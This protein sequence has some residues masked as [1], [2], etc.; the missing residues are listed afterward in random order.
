MKTLLLALCIFQLF[1]TEIKA[2]LN[3]CFRTKYVYNMG[4]QVDYKQKTHF[5][6]A[7]QFDGSFIVNMAFND[8]NFSE[9]VPR[10]SV[11]A[12][13]LGNKTTSLEFFFTDV[14]YKK[15]LILVY[16]EDNEI[17]RVHTE[18]L[19]TTPAGQILYYR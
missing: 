6:F 14:Y 10:E 18:C 3:I 17:G 19:I 13:D 2:Q 15:M 11:I 1:A 12:K 4:T 7:Q 5:N 16:S 9:V 8:I